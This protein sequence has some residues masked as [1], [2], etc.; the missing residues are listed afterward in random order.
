MARVIWEKLVKKQILYG[1]G[2]SVLLPSLFAVLEQ[3]A[4]RFRQHPHRKGKSV[5]VHRGMIKRGLWRDP[6]A[7]GRREFDVQP[8]SGQ[9]AAVRD[10]CVAI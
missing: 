3:A 9:I 7:I 10:L 5:T 8:L 4:Q 2:G 1:E 6:A